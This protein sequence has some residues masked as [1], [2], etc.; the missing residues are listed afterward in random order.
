MSH[1][2]QLVVQAL[3]S[4]DLEHDPL[5]ETPVDRIGA[6]AKAPELGRAVRHLQSH[7]TAA[8]WNRA[9]ELLV[10]ATFGRARVGRI[11]G[12]LCEAVLLERE[13]GLCRKCVGRKFVIDGAVQKACTSCS[14]TG[15][16]RHSDAERARSIGVPIGVYQKNWEP[17]FNRAHA[18]LSA[19]NMATDREVYAQLGR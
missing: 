10:R 9:R 11:H 5:V 19:A 8:Q 3:S 15:L 4:G 2:Q 7:A 17:M 1:I 6:L 13:I 14:G 16:W 12:R 18:K